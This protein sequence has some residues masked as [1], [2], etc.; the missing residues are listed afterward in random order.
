MKRI[1]KVDYPV[2]KQQLYE[3]QNGVCA[4]CK[5]PLDGDLN[6][7]HLDHDHELHGDSAGRVRGLL[8]SLC[9]ATEGI[10]KHKFN[11]SGLVSGGV[12]YVAWLRSLANYVD[13]DYTDNPIHDKFIPDKTKWFSRLTKTEMIQEMKNEDFLYL[14]SDERKILTKKYRKQLMDKT[15]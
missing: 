1:K 13:T 9:N 7:H 4:L 2:V 8:C 11:R 12:D 6:Q 14:E 5:R 10:V 15:K 3:K